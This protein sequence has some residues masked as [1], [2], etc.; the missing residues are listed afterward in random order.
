LVR[1]HITLG[2]CGFGEPKPFDQ[3]SYR[4]AFIGQSPYLH[5][6]FCS[7]NHLF[8]N[9]SCDT[10]FPFISRFFASETIHFSD[11]QRRESSTFHHCRISRLIMGIA[12]SPLNCS[13]RIFGPS[14]G[15][16]SNSNTYIQVSYI[17]LP[18]RPAI[19]TNCFVCFQ[20]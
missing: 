5:T 3:S 20:K 6:A 19:A 11:L 16:G 4:Y 17:M 8:R 12:W 9:W 10:Q 15:L 2:G 1:F 18:S 13:P 7:A 14:C